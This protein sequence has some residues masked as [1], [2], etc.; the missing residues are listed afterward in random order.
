MQRLTHT[1]V[2]QPASKPTDLVRRPEKRVITVQGHVL[3]LNDILDFASRLG[4]LPVQI[5]WPT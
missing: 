5:A 4:R 2:L 3:S 1:F